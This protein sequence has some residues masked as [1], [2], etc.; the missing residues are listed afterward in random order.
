MISTGNHCQYTAAGQSDRQE[1][2]QGFAAQLCSLPR[3]TGVV[4]KSPSAP[5]AGNPK[6]NNGPIDLT[7]LTSVRSRRI[8]KR[9]FF[10][11]ATVRS[12]EVHYAAPPSSPSQPRNKQPYP[13]SRPRCQLGA[14]YHLDARFKPIC[15]WGQGYPKRGPNHSGGNRNTYPHSN[16]SATK[17]DRDA[18]TIY[19]SPNRN[20]ANHFADT[21]QST[22]RGYGNSITTCA[23]NT[24]SNGTTSCAGNRD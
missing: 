5:H 15:A 21:D 20:R 16:R 13:I 17:W 4:P 10:H 22:T 14:S 1:R 7:D 18:I 24:H 12:T 11:R 3:L 6:S 8:D 19:S 2:S 9:S 23:A